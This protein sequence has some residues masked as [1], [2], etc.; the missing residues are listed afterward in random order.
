MSGR[1][2]YLDSDALTHQYRDMTTTQTTK[3]SD[4]TIATLGTWAYGPA[5]LIASYHDET[6]VRVEV[7]G[8]SRVMTEREWLQMYDDIRDAGYTRQ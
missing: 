5:K 7:D 3:L 4:D 8:L 6:T 2:F 1:N